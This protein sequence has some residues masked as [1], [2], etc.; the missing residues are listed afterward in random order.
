MDLDGRNKRDVSGRDAGF[1]YG[2]SASSNGKFISYHE[3]YQVYVADADG[4]NKKHIKTSNAFNFAPSWSPEW[5]VAPLC[6]RRA[7]QLSSLYRSP[8]WLWTEKTCRSWWLSGVIEFLDVF[9]FPAAAAT[10]RSGH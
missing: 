7:L 9:D 10:F 6:Q 4:R 5:K 8:R 3:N 2:Y 1:T